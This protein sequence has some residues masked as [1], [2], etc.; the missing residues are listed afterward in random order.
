MENERK[1]EKNYVKILKILQPHKRDSVNL[2]K[3]TNLQF[4]L[5]FPP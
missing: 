1:I 4:N 5:Q 3:S 2:Q